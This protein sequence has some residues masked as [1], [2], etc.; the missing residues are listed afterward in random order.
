[1]ET[2][3]PFY[4][5]INQGLVRFNYFS[6]DDKVKSKIHNSNRSGVLSSCRIRKYHYNERILLKLL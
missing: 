2:K 5:N 4:R 1:M 6:L 3:Y